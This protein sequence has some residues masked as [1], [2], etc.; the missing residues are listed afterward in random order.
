MGAR[1]DPMTSKR[2]NKDF[3]KGKS[4]PV[5]VALPATFPTRGRCKTNRCTNEKRLVVSA[6]ISRL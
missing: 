2:G 6:R 3:Y 1:R 4:Y 5:V